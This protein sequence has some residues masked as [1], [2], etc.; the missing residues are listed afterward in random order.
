MFG[1]KAIQK[2]SLTFC[3]TGYQ[4]LGQLSCLCKIFVSWLISFS[5]SSLGIFFEKLILL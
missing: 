5:S 1:L 3:S 2:C 4:L